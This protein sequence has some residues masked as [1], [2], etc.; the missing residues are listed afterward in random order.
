MMNDEGRFHTVNY[1]WNQM[2]IDIHIFNEYI[3][4]QDNSPC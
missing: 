4:N 1:L 2:E 3:V